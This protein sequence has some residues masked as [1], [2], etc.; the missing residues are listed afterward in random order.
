MVDDGGDTVCLTGIHLHFEGYIDDIHEFPTTPDPRI[1]RDDE[2][3]S[4]G[5][6]VVRFRES[7]LI[8]RSTPHRH[9]VG[10]DVSVDQIIERI[11]TVLGMIVGKR[12][13]QP[14][15]GILPVTSMI[16]PLTGDVHPDRGSE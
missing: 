13:V 9:I 15:H 4:E 10:S 12:Q 7:L 8:A 1:Y 11:W 14:Q 16:T 6:K 5:G 2:G 3:V